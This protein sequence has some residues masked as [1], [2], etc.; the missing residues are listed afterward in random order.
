MLLYFTPFQ[1]VANSSGPSF[2]IAATSSGLVALESTTINRVWP[3]PSGRTLRIASISGDDF[4]I[5]LGSSTIDAASSDGTLMLGGTV[6]LMRIQPGQSYL[7]FK[8]S[9][10]VS[11]NL[12]LGVGQ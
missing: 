11:F 8:S 3:Y 7:S 1:P 2:T 5:K 4:Y 12:T 9:T 6:E 10:D